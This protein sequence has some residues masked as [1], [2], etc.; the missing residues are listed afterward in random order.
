[1]SDFNAK[2]HQVQFWLGICP[3]P[4]GRTY[5]ASLDPLAGL[6]G[7]YFK[8]EGKE[9]REG[10]TEKDGRGRERGKGEEMGR[11]REERGET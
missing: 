5:S 1:M 10:R 11:K 7:S 6:K 2:T 9:G 8:G 4:A 3:R